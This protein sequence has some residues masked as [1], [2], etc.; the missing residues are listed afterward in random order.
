MNLLTPE[1]RE[2]VERARLKIREDEAFDSSNTLEGSLLAI[3]DSISQREP[4]QYTEEEMKSAYNDYEYK[5]LKTEA[6]YVRRMIYAGGGKS[7]I[8]SE[9]MAGWLMCA[10]FLGAL[11][12]DT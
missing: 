11:K 7:D 2:T 5:I 12:A 9:Y 3:I 10:K 8:R 6:E 1:E 4:K